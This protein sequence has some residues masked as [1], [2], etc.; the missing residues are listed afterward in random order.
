MNILLWVLQILLAVHTVIG[1]VWKFSNSEQ[2]VPSLS[3]IPHGAWLAMSVVELACALGLILPA[4]H[5]PLGILAP[6]AAA[7]IAAE[8]LLFCGLHLSSGD[9]NYGPMIYWLVV[10]AICAFVAYGR[11]V[12][13][14]F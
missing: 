6:V 11:F 10:A 7:F 12:L 8:M 5:K 9:A 1:A 14:P 2:T 3:A 13:K 4:F